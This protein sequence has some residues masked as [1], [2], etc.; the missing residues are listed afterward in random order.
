M[1]DLPVQR[2]PIAP[3][4]APEMAPLPAVVRP[5]IDTALDLSK[6]CRPPK[7]A[8]RPKGIAENHPRQS[9]YFK[10]GTWFSRL[11]H[12]WPS[13]QSESRARICVD[14]IK[15][16]SAKLQ[17]LPK[18][19][20]ESRKNAHEIMQA[21]QELEQTNRTVINDSE[22]DIAFK[23]ITQPNQSLLSNVNPE[24]TINP[25]ITETKLNNDSNVNT[26]KENV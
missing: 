11:N 19:Q 6:V 23:Y 21:L 26:G 22:R 20:R 9:K 7:S 3:A 5:S 16:L 15:I 17:V 14:M 13:L 25:N 1:S 10:I 4:G 2:L 18:S 24:S 8:G 12:E